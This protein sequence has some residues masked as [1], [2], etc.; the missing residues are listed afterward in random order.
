VTG[1]TLYW[2]FRDVALVEVWAA[3][4]RANAWLLLLMVPCQILGLWLRAVRWRYLTEPI[5]GGPVPAGPLFRATAVG[6]MALNLLPLRIGEIVR[7]W[8]LARETGIRASAALGTVVIERAVDFA[9]V[10]LIGGLVLA[11]HTQ[12]LPAWVRSGAAL[13]AGLSLLPFAL[14]LA[15]RAN[16]E[17][18]VRLA[19]R[20]L[21]FLP[22]RAA[23]RTLDVL[24]QMARGLAS[25]RTTRDTLMVLAYSALLWGIVIAAP[26]ALGLPA[27]AIG[28]GS[29]QALLATYTALAFTAV[30]V[31]VPAA[32]GF[33][34]VYHFAC[35]EALAL[36]GVPPA[37]AVGYGTALHL[38]YWVPVTLVGLASLARSRLRL[39]DLTAP[40]LGKAG[41]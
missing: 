29:A 23:S 39:A 11:L 24:G 13:V 6:F 28:L 37:V 22:A 20:L 19:I 2:T 3:L 5:A 15:I 12:T 35:R 40:P 38:A 31:A 1:L 17:R 21:G 4:A 33:F 27:F 32:P 30:A 34:G 26:F 14:T 9:F 41:A 18:S 10:A 25:L 8:V 16:G 7:P 36:F